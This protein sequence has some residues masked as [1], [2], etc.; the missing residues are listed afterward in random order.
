MENESGDL[1]ELNQY[2]E[3][4]YLIAEPVHN[5][6]RLNKRKINEFISF[7]SI[8]TDSQIL[9]DPSNKTKSLITLG[10]PTTGDRIEL[11]SSD[12][13]TMHRVETQLNYQKERVGT[14]IRARC[15]AVDNSIPDRPAHHGLDRLIESLNGLWGWTFNLLEREP[16]AF[17]V[18]V[19]LDSTNRIDIE[20][21][22]DKLKTLLDCLSVSQQIGFYIQEVVIGPI[23]R[24]S[25]NPYVL[26]VGPQE[27]LLGSLSYDE[28]DNIQTVL[29]LP[30]A[31]SASR[32][33]NQAY[34]ENFMPSK[35]AMLS[36]AVEDVFG[37]DPTPLLN[38]S[39]IKNLMKAARAIGTL[40]SDNERTS[41][42]KQALEGFK[43]LSKNRRMATVIAPIMGM[44]E[45]EILKKLQMASKM[46]GEQLHS[47]RGGWDKLQKS[48]GFLQEVL[49]RYLSQ[50]MNGE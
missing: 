37:T 24:C 26:D 39:E 47:I 19:S 14:L 49:R 44:G 31:K 10:H 32:G 38:R 15:V 36:A 45:N 18:E 3:N 48:V 41:D 12:D 8:E 50:K 29:S 13:A 33:L 11:L 46:R 25:L 42:L 21:V 22:K 6:G 9:L 4:G 43:R 23:R 34:A 27:R 5:L 16:P 40:G 7:F 28:I 2:L 1:K 17:Q 30:K 20:I 35:L